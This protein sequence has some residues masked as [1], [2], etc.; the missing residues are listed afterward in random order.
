M[1]ETLNALNIKVL[2]VFILNICGQKLR[3]C[4]PKPVKMAFLNIEVT[5]L[6]SSFKINCEFNVFVFIVILSEEECNY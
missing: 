3:K 2:I 5:N 6:L 1:E 4:V